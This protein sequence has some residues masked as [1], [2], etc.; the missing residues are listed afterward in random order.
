[1]DIGTQLNYSF[2]IPHHNS[3][4][5]L[6]RCLE[7]IPQREDIEIIVVDDNS[8][9]DK[10]PKQM[11]R[12]GLEIIF[13]DAN[14]SK[15]AGRA[16]NVGIKHAK[17]K[18]LLFADADDLYKDGFINI[19]DEYVDKD[20]EIL[21]FNIDSVDSLS[22]KS[23]IGTKRDRSAPTRRIIDCYS[24]AN[25]DSLLYQSYG[26]WNKMI[27]KDVVFSYG[28]FYEEVY[29]GNDVLFS[30]EIG[31]V[32]KK[33]AVDKRTLYSLT[34][35]PN[36][37]TYQ[38]MSSQKFESYIYNTL[39]MAYFN[40]KIGHPEWN[41]V[42]RFAFLAP[43]YYII[44]LLIKKPLYGVQAMFYF[45]IH[46]SSIYKDANKYAN[47]INSLGGVFLPA[48]RFS[49]KGTIMLQFPNLKIAA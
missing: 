47:V 5:L 2:I 38:P 25:A 17:G 4:N 11:N 41:N 36:S 10:K 8:D 9:V 3:P 37:L 35:Y 24:Q 1:M 32:V 15:G 49:Q 20:I 43:L 22:L 28:I 6:N 16:R 23:L 33:Y 45:I 31:S 18:W 30:L 21:Y 42:W 14:Q 26:P 48:I 19:L 7:S 44:K 12:A 29:K 13:L 46:I 39:H 40:N 27:L 34:Y